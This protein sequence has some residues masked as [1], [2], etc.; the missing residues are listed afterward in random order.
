M[1]KYFPLLSVS[2]SSSYHHRPVSSQWINE[3]TD[4]LVIIHDVVIIIIGA[5]LL[6]EAST[7]NS[8]L[9]L[10]KLTPV[11]GVVFPVGF[12][13]LPRPRRDSA[14]TGVPSGPIGYKI[15]FETK[16]D[17]FQLQSDWK[18]NNFKVDV[19]SFTNNYKYRQIFTHTSLLALSKKYI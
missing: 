15:F 19:T 14:R 13:A 11:V 9:Q 8:H 3:Q 12:L 5:T 18:T 1:G 4:K 6:L 2:S 16:P 7:C 10:E 17:P